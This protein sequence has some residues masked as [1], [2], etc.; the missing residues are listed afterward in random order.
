MPIK[1]LATEGEQAEEEE[2]FPE[3]KYTPTGKPIPDGYHWDGTR[4]VKTYK[5]SKRL[6]IGPIRFVEDA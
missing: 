6:G 3:T 2:M 1:A 5:G 4:L